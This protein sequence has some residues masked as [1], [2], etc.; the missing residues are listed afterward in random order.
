[1]CLYVFTVGLQEPPGCTH[2]A[3]VHFKHFCHHRTSHSLTVSTNNAT[4][5]RHVL[6][7][8]SPISPK[9]NLSGPTCTRLNLMARQLRSEELESWQFTKYALESNLWR[10]CIHRIRTQYKKHQV[11]KIAVGLDE[12][13]CYKTKIWGVRDKPTHGT[14]EETNYV[15]NRTFKRCLRQIDLTF[16]TMSCYLMGI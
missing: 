13:F 6:L 12:S 14:N 8:S 4:H 7:S 3:D 2:V 11:V 9:R 16:W 10:P 1:M 15:H 5:C